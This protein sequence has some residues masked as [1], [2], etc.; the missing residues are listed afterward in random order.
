MQHSHP[1]LGGRKGQAEAGIH[2]FSQSKCIT[3]SPAIA[4]TVQLTQHHSATRIASQEIEEPLGNNSTATANISNIVND[5]VVNRE[6]NE[7]PL[8]F[9][10]AVA[11]GE[12][13]RVLPS[14][15]P[16]G[17]YLRLWILLK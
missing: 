11:L 13:G 10:Q 8:S 17:K 15:V 9:E 3:H 5:N 14:P 4:I 16:M 1:S 6:S 7:T 12:V 2:Q